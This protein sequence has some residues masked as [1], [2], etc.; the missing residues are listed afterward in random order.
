MTSIAIS[1][2]ERVTPDKFIEDSLALPTSKDE[3]RLAL[4]YTPA[5]FHFA[6]VESSGVSLADDAPAP[7]RDAY[8]IRVFCSS[9]EARWVRSGTTGTSFVIRELGD[10]ESAPEGDETEGD[11]VVTE[12]RQLLWGKVIESSAGWSRFRDSRIGILGAPIE[13]QSGGR[14]WLVTRSYHTCNDIAERDT[15]GV[16]RLVGSRLVRLEEA[17]E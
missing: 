9:H 10:D 8:E 17:K 11:V 6:T 15:Y 12:N 14:A 13:L 3:R 1:S 5:G 4:L 2:R 16:P 7:Y